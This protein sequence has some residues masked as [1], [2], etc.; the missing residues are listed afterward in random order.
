MEVNTI[1]PRLEI[2]KKQHLEI[3]RKMN[4]STRDTVIKRVN[5][6]TTAVKNKG[7]FLEDSI[8]PFIK[9]ED[10]LV[11]YFPEKNIASQ[12]TGFVN[13]EGVGKYGVE[14][15]FENILQGEG[16]TQ[17]VVKDSANRPIG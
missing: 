9:I 8:L 15:Y 12:I 11:R 14:G 16:P 1:L 7:L 10:N 5:S 17:R 13:S 4:V 2:R 3:I 6:E